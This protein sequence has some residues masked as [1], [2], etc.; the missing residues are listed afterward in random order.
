MPP[1]WHENGRFSVSITPSAYSDAYSQTCCSAPDEVR[2]ILNRAYLSSRSDEA[3]FL[4]DV[5]WSFRFGAV[6]VAGP[7]EY[8]LG[9]QT[10]RIGLLEM[11]GEK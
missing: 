2:T 1:L 7:A 6:V 4:L 5:Y 10:L 8:L 9:Q 11:K 3:I